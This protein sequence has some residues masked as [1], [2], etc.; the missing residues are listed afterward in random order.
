MDAKDIDT[1][2]TKGGHGRMVDPMLQ[3]RQNLSMDR[4]NSRI[5]PSIRE[6][7]ALADAAASCVVH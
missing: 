1:R 3:R 4:T 5:F 2:G 6:A 7:A